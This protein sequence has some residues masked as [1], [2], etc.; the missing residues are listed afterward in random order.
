MPMVSFGGDENVL[1]DSDNSSTTLD[2]LK[3]T[4]LH[5]KKGC[6]GI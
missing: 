6:F 2:L 4:E 3:A 5:T 1:T